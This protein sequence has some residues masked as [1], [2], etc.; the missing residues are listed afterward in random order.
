RSTRRTRASAWT[1][2]ATRKQSPEQEKGLVSAPFFRLARSFGSPGRFRCQLVPAGKRL[3]RV[4]ERWPAAHLDRHGEHVAEF[5]PRGAGLHQRLDMEVDAG[6]AAQRQRHAEGDV[7]L[8]LQRERTV[9]L[10]SLGERGEALRRA[11]DGLV[12]LAQF[13]TGFVDGVKVAH[14][15]LRIGLSGPWQQIVPET[16]TLIKT[17][18]IWNVTSPQRLRHARQRTQAASE[19]S[20]A[21][22][23]T[24]PETP[25]TTPVPVYCQK[26]QS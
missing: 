4:H 7:F 22:R 17:C 1:A 13:G 25:S 21:L 8:F 11:G 16:F 23:S 5:L 26:L 2:R 10:H 24:A 18:T 14:G 6:R 15:G 12:E 20:K 3:A 9:V 19:P